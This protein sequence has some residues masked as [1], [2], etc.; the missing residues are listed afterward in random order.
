MKGQNH[1][2]GHP[3]VGILHS[4]D[5]PAMLTDD[6]MR[7]SQSESRACLFGRIERIEYL[8]QVFCLD[9]GPFIG[10]CGYIALQC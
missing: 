4:F 8:V 2:E 7:N 1:S 6:L 9:T 5:N 10:N 3:L